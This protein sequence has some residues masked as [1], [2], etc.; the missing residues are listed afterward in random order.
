MY[1]IIGVDGRVYG[2][3]SADE[4]RHWI[5]T[6]RADAATLVEAHGSS[7]WR[8]LATFPELTGAPP[9]ARGLPLPQALPQ[10]LGVAKTNGMAVTSF[11]LGLASLVIGWCCGGPLLPVL[12]IVF[13]CIAIS[14]I[15]R[16]P[17]RQTGKGLA[18]TG[19]AL[20]IIGLVLYVLIIIFLIVLS[21][22]GNWGGKFS[23]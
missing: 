5:A 6:G 2:P 19:L 16:D 23:V 22:S 1:R 20:S 21:L 18:V 14:Q 13:A 9:I 11:G 3:V 4:L 10:H 7:E 17:H 15:N 8:P 12:G